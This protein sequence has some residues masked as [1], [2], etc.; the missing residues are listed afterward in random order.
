MASLRIVLTTSSGALAGLAEA[1]PEMTVREVPLLSFV[2]LE[3]WTP[4]DR[5]LETLA[6]FDA[7]AFTSPR[8][9]QAVSAR[10]VGQIEIPVWVVGP[11]TAA[12]LQ[13]LAPSLHQASAENGVALARGMIAAGIKGPVLHFCGDVHRDG[14]PATLEAAGVS[15]V[16]VVCYRSRLAGEAAAGA[17]LDGAD[18]VVAGSPRVAELLASVRGSGSRPAL[19]A[20]GPTT[21][22]AARIAGWPPDAQAPEPTAAAVALSLRQLA[23]GRA[24]SA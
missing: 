13:K 1:L 12:P 2:P 19:L 3:D 10:T 18:I 4:V 11:A 6:D 17:A 7:V 5:A 24:A 23:A 20:L 21:A 9:A 22:A 15:V 16:A 8:A 14:F